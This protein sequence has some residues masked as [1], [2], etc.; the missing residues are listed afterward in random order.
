MTSDLIK[1]L[2]S[3][4]G[5]DRTLDAKVSCALYGYVMH[6]ESDPSDGV[7]AFWD[8]GV[9]HNCSSW[10][11][12]TASVDEAMRLVPEGLVWE[13]Y[14]RTNYIRARVLEKGPPFRDDYHVSEWEE[15]GYL[16]DPSPAIA[17]CIAA[18]KA[19]GANNA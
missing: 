16:R 6:E 2:E 1:E 17:L 5:P 3:A 9:C 8:D 12:Y 10:P 18:L 15:G 11:E 7:F 14:V 13:L 4:S 19:N